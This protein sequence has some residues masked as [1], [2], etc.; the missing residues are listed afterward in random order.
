ML[1]ECHPANWC[2]CSS[3][4][5]ELNTLLRGRSHKPG[6]VPNCLCREEARPNLPSLKL[7]A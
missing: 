5:P 7:A 6:M 2:Q 3:L 1:P 4:I